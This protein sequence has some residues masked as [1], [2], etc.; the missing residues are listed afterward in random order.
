M[1]TRLELDE[2]SEPVPA[3]LDPTTASDLAALDLVE[4]RPSVEG[5]WL[6]VPRPNRVGAV[7]IGELDVVVRPKASFASILFM[8]GYARDPGFRPDLFD[9]TVDRDLWPMV[10]ETLTRL[11]ER[12][13][14]RGVI[15][16][17]VTRDDAL[18]LV[19]GRIRTADQM[20]RHHG[21]PLPLE[22]TFDEY[23]V[24]IP[25]N[26]L[27][28]T[29]LVRMSHVARLPTSLRRRLLHLVGRLEG[30][31]V[32]ERGAQLPAWR[33]TRLN[34][35]YHPA[36]RLADVVLRQLGLATREGRQPTASFVVDMAA[37][38]EDFVT[39]AAR[40]SLARH[41]LGVTTGQYRDHLDAGRRVPIRP[42]IVH[43]AGHRPVLVMDAKYK[44]GSGVD[45]YPTSD[46]YQMLAYCTA[47]RLGRGY[48]VYAGSR[49]AD[50]RPTRLA[51]RNTD[52]EVITW[53]LDVE[54]AP[55]ALLGQIDQLA[56]VAAESIAT[57]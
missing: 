6:L 34:A 35:A 13:L 41:A 39:V 38:F 22:V 44:L 1:A 15:Q 47:L 51:I 37:T 31:Q 52:V 8:Q 30:V 40:E 26:R 36:L 27:L 53:P 7:R 29:A 50:A 21:L 48:L 14:L 42:D 46:V 24:D 18:S 20:S 3:R 12:A 49:A 56:S 32:L 28:R 43:S 2:N 16:G 55:V 10:A 5:P 17:Y 45:G 54:E 19:R 57:C 4:V 11:A 33:P 23:D 9:G 25:E